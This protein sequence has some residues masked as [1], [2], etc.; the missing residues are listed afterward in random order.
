[1]S[2]PPPFVIPGGFDPRFSPLGR[3]LRRRTGDRLRAE[4]LQIALLTGAALAGLMGVYAAE[5]AAGLFGMPS[6]ALAGGLAGASL[7]AGL[8]AGVVGRRPRAVVRVGPQ[9]VTV[10][11]GREQM[12]LLYDTMGPPAVVAARRFHRHERRY[13]AVRPFLGKTA[14]P[15]LLLRAREGPIAALGLPDEEDRQALRRHVEERVE[16]AKAP[17]EGAAWPSPARRREA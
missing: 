13:A 8:G 3:A 7:L 10:E 16:A 4:A 14:T 17:C 9:A 12:R 1:V 11:R 2:A 5:A 6:L 15:V